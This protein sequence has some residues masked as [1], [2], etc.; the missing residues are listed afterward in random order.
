MTDYD[1][2]FQ[3]S[4]AQYGV[5]AVLLE[6]IARRESSLRPW[7]D[8]NPPTDGVGLM[9]MTEATARGLGYQGTREGLK[10]PATSIDLGA[11]YAAQIIAHQGGLYLPDFY[12]EYNSG[13]PTLW[14]SSSQVA[15][16]VRG[17][18]GEYA[19]ALGVSLPE[20]WSIEAVAAQLSSSVQGQ[21]IPFL[22]FVLAFGIYLF[23]K[24]RP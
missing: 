5:P 8:P 18:L 12:S 13:R 22:M 14:Q 3:Q 21:D 17:F 9:G 23:Q 11:R 20:N 10:D 7:V 15:A 19:A 24:G 1:V 4:A 16:N 6:A 2:F